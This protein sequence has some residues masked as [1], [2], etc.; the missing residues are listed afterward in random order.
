[1]RG[2][3]Q[4]N[5]PPCLTW[6]SVREL[7]R[8]RTLRTIRLAWQHA[9]RRREEKGAV[10]ETPFPPSP[11]RNA[12]CVK[13]ISEPHKRWVPVLIELGIKRRPHTTAVTPM[14]QYA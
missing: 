4:K 5:Q 2:S 7:L 10:T 13:Q 9:N 14:R 8:Y 12:E 3:W 6:R 1:M 11:S